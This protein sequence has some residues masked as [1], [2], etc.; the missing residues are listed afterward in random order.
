MSRRTIVGF[1]VSV[2]D[3]VAVGEIQRLEELV[4]VVADVDVC[5]LWV[6]YL[7]VCVVDGFENERW[8]FGLWIANDVVEFDYVCTSAQVLQNLD[9]SFDLLLLHRFEDLDHALG[10]EHHVDALKHLRVLATSNLAH[11]LVVVH[12][13]SRQQ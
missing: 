7:E 11:N 13:A 4:H 8:G 1:H 2:H 10:V 3:S 5:E 12:I 9:L 6:E